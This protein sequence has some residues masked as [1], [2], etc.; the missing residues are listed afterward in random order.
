MEQKLQSERTKSGVAHEEIAALN[1]QN[2][3]NKRQL[4]EST[5]RLKEA[6]EK[7][8][9]DK[10]DTWGGVE[11]YDPQEMDT[12]GESK[13]QLWETI[14]ELDDEEMSDTIQESTYKSA[15]AA[16]NEIGFTTIQM[17]KRL[18]RSE[19]QASD[20][21]ILVKNTTMRIVD[22]IGISSEEVSGNQN[23]ANGLA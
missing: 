19:L 8:H 4:E 21:P 16:F 2:L 13:N 5:M 1:K 22:R 11:K 9:V 15:A 7:F 3:E 10:H 6:T 14:R 12:M 17:I 20:I 18:T 23:D